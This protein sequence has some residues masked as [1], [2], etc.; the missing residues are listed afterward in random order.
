MA[1]PKNIDKHAILSAIEYI[2]TNGTPQTNQSVTYDLVVENE[3][4]SPKYV[5]A[6]ANHLTNNAEISTD[7]YNSVDTVN[8][9]KSLGFTIETKQVKYTLVITADSVTST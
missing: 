4:F 8:F 9:L 5:I 7:G 2:K 3:K 1:I 6:V